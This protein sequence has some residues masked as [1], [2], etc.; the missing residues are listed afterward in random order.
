MTLQCGKIKFELDEEGVQNIETTHP[1]QEETTLSEKDWI[2][3]DPFLYPFR[4]SYEGKRFLSAAAMT[5][6]YHYKQYAYQDVCEFVLVYDNE[7]C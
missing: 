7:T 4:L 5:K 3:K 2:E 6:L 1:C